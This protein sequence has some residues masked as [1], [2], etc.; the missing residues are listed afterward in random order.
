MGK[1][2]YSS[3]ILYLSRFTPLYK[4]DRRLGGLQNWFGRCEGEKN[5]RKMVEGKTEN[6]LF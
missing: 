4:L 1:W 5:R 3:T 2:R 6:I